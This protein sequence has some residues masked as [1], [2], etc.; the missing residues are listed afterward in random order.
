VCRNTSRAGARQALSEYLEPKCSHSQSRPVFAARARATAIEAKKSTS[1][2]GVVFEERTLMAVGGRVSVKQ[3]VATND[4][5]VVD[6]ACR[7]NGIGA[8][9]F[10]FDASSR[11]FGG[12]AL[13]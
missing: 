11:K 1:K 10:S 7:D 3:C 2:R 5:D 12:A 4:D 6:E 8:G 13:T 9:D